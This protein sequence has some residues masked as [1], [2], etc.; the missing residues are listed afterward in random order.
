MLSVEKK[1]T[2]L[3]SPGLLSLCQKQTHR[4]HLDNM[5][6]R[7]FRDIFFKIFDWAQRT[8]PQQ[9]HG[10]IVEETTIA[11]EKIETPAPEGALVNICFPGDRMKN[12]GL[13]KDKILIF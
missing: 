12:K 10:F 6:G 2:I 4:S 7:Y 1:M 13:E 11:P 5:R 3:L 8:V 9:L